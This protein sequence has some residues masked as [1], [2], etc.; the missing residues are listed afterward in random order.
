MLSFL[1]MTLHLPNAI[2][3]PSIIK[4]MTKADKAKR[5]AELS[6]LYATSRLVL[7]HISTE[8]HQNIPNGIWVP[9]RTQQNLFQTKQRGITPKVKKQEL[10]FLYATCCLILFYTSSKYYQ[11]IP[12]GILVTEPTQNQFKKQNKER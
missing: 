7:F 3:L 2:I 10:S 11:N 6:F 8:Y 9:K 4:N 1:Y 12:K 5:K